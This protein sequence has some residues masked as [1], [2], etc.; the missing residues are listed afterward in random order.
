MAFRKGETYND[1][2][3][4]RAR[5]DIGDE[6]W[7]KRVMK[8]IDALRSLMFFDRCWIGGGNAKRL[9]TDKLADDTTI[10][11]NTAG[12]LGGIKL[13]EEAHFGL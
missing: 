9:E 11:D 4:E 12:I 3:G 1:Q 5:K 7:N 13:W 10:V 2:L 6:R 8:A